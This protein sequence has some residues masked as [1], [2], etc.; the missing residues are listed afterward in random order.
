MKTDINKIVDFKKIGE[1]T[2]PINFAELDELAKKDSTERQATGDITRVLLVGIDFQYCFMEKTG[3]LGVDG[4]REDV[5]RTISWLY[6]YGEK[7]TR[8]MLSMDDHVMQ[9][10]FFPCWWVDRN[11]NNPKPYTIIMHDEVNTTWIPNFDKLIPYDAKMFNME[12]N[13]CSEYVR[14]LE[15]GG[16]QKLQI[17]PYHAIAGGPDSNIEAQLLAMVYYHS[18]C[19]GMNPYIARKG[20]D[21]WTEMY[22]LIKPEWSLDNY[23]NLPVLEEM[24]K[25]DIIIFTGEAASHCAGLTVLDTAQYFSE[26][27]GRKPQ[28]V[29]FRDCMSA[30]PTF[31]IHTEN[32][33]KTLQDKYGVIVT[34]ST[35]FAL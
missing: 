33:Y 2:T 12:V 4:S 8:V 10:I 29:V 20:N 16:R 9:Q 28:F 23:I 34:E 3:T 18:R 24:A 5:K 27:G 1:Y 17:W 30:I 14:H 22:S 31:E 6:N 26:K 32:L 13:Y 21:P 19:R 25:Y 15:K 11:G 35:K 7:V